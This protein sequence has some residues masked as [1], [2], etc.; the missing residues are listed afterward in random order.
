MIDHVEFIGLTNF[1]SNHNQPSSIT[2][3]E[4]NKV[5]IFNSLFSNNLQGDDYVNFFR[6]KNINLKNLVFKNVIADAIF[7]RF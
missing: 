5:E 4:C 6:S 7:S 1:N 2:F 3:Y